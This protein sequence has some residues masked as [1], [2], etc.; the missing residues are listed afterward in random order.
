MAPKITEFNRQNCRE[1]STELLGFLT[2]FAEQHGLTV[3]DE[4]GKFNATTYTPK[5]TF[6]VP[7]ENLGAKKNVVDKTFNP[8][9]PANGTIT[10]AQA[11]S[12]NPEYVDFAV[13]KKGSNR[14]SFYLYDKALKKGMTVLVHDG[15][16]KGKVTFKVARISSVG[17]DMSGEKNSK[18]RV[19]DGAYSWRIDSCYIIP[20]K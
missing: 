16:G 9:N 20:I 10:E 18:V 8:K 5:F 6:Q 11:R 19:T 4:G 14:S 3:V 2:K 15:Y 1:L 7:T 17:M 12:I 13:G